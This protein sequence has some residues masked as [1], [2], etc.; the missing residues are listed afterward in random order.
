MSFCLTAGDGN[1][2]A[3]WF[4]VSHGSIGRI[5]TGPAIKRSGVWPL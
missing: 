4:R 3:P 5:F 1:V 2:F